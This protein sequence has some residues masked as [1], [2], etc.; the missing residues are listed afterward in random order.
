MTQLRKRNVNRNA[1]LIVTKATEQG[2]SYEEIADICNV[3]IG[4]VKRWLSTGRADAGKIKNLEHIVGHTYLQPESVG[5]ILIEIYRSRNKRYRLKRYQLKQISGRF[6]LRTSFVKQIT[7]YLSD[8]GYFMLESVEGEEDF[9]IILR[10]KQAL[11][12]VKDYLEP[13]DIKAYYRNISDEID[14]SEDED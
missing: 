8:N 14:D 4:S 2:Y 7:R 6:T 9:F 10:I 12:H 3:S 11:K 5:D 13:S 1:R